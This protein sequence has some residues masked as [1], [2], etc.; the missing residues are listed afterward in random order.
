MRT[1]ASLAALVLLGVALAGCTGGDD[2]P[3]ETPSPRAPR[4]SPLGPRPA[5][6]TPNATHAEAP[7]AVWFVNV[8]RAPGIVLAGEPFVVNVSVEGP[9]AAIERLELLTGD[10][11][12]GSASGAAPANLTVTCVLGE[13]GDA[14][15]AAR[16]FVQGANWTS[17]PPVDVRVREPIAD[18]EATLSGAPA[19][20]VAPGSSF[21]VRVRADGDAPDQ[22]TFEARFGPNST[23]LPSAERYPIPC[24]ARVQEVPGEALLACAVPPDAPPGAYYLRGRVAVEAGAWSREFWSIEEIIVVS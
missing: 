19:F 5:N 13:P 9:A 18:Y 15:L 1:R 2:A 17:A 24:A 12:C 20:P 4:V 21:E 7:P 22:A 23:D 11:A 16:A 14:R 10:A 8:T 6:A 3:P